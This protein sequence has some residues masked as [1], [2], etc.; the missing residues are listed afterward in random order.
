MVLVGLG[1]EGSHELGLL[2]GGLEASVSELGRGVDELEVDLLEGDALGVLEE[3]LAEGDD[4]LLGADDGA[5]E[6]EPVLVDHSVV[7]ESAHGVDALLGEIVLSGRGLGIASLS[8]AV[9][10]LV[11]L[12]AVVVSVLSS[13]GGGVAHARRMPR[14]DARNLPETLVGLAGKAGDAPA[15][16]DA[17]ESLT[18][19]DADGVE[20]LV[21]GE[22]VVDGDGLLEEESSRSR[23]SPQRIL[24]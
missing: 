21:L 13:A 24:R 6:H 20:H 7:G 10:L 8:D 11:D 16:D 1:G 2:G 14:S 15:G 22:H 3:R 12:R 5:L 23:P 9:D 18:L 19:G 17:L 4:A